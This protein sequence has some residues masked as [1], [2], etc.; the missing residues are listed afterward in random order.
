MNKEEK[1]LLERYMQ[2]FNNELKVFDTTPKL[3]DLSAIERKAFKLG[4][5][6]A[7]AGDIVS[8]FD[9]MSDEEILVEIKK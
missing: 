4:R 5:V 3:Y 8:N 7:L 2:G 9:F 6:H 1:K